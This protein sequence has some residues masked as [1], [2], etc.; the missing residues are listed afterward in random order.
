MLTVLYFIQR[1]AY[2]RVVL[3]CEVTATPSRG[4]DTAR[5]S[6]PQIIAMQ[7]A[8]K[9]SNLYILECSLQCIH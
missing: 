3:L 8:V 6:K 2:S 4:T 9:L 7:K 1:V 5:F